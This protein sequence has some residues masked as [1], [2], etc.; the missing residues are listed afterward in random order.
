MSEIKCV[1]ENDSE[2]ER[3]PKYEKVRGY[4][5]RGL[6]DLRRVK[7]AVIKNWITSE[8]FRLITG[9]EF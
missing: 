4:Y 8:E 6:W 9:T 1:S 5:V 3:S 2:V 7:N